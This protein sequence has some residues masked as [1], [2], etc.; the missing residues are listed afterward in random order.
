MKEQFKHEIEGTATGEYKGGFYVTYAG[1]EYEAVYLGIG[2]FV[3]YADVPDEYV[4]FPV[5]GG[6]YILQTDLRDELLTCASEIRMI[7]I[8]KQEYESVMIR[9]IFEEGIVVS[10]YNPR[11][12]FELNLKPVKELGFTGLVDRD[13]LIDYYEERD[14]LWNPKLGVYA[15]FCQGTKVNNEN[16]WFVEKDRYVQVCTLHFPRLQQ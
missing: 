6:K 15:T 9:D 2:R 10:T 7:G 14:Y 13:V 5:K 8:V 3:L 4:T 12:A 11:L 1:R 16:S